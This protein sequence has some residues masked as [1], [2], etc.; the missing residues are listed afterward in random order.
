MNVV[1]VIF[2]AALV[3][4]V[5]SDSLWDGETPEFWARCKECTSS[6]KVFCFTTGTCLDLDI[7]APADLMWR[8]CMNPLLIPE[9][10]R[11]KGIHPPGTPREV[12]EKWQPEL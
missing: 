10:C 6:R 4:Q 8:S 2:G 12:M 3:L 5:R 7:D 1:K 11:T 9:S